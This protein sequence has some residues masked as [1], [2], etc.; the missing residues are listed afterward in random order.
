MDS[1]KKFNLSLTKKLITLKHSKYCT[2][3]FKDAEGTPKRLQK[4]W[5][6]LTNEINPEFSFK[7]LKIKYNSLLSTYKQHDDDAMRS[8]AAAVKWKY[9]QL[10]YET[11]SKRISDSILPDN[12][13]VGL[14]SLTET[15]IRLE[16]TEISCPKIINKTKNN[17]KNTYL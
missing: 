14:G 9:W 8:G 3:K 1:K 7:E 5:K 11:I 17:L 15:E 6:E 12:E 2:D 10:L 16:Q 4:V 13:G